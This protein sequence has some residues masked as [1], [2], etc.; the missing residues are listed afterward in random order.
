MSGKGRA[1]GSDAAGK[2]TK[3]Q[4][5]ERVRKEAEDLK[6]AEAQ[7]KGKA[8]GRPSGPLCKALGEAGYNDL[9]VPPDVGPDGVKAQPDTPASG[10]EKPAGTQAGGSEKPGGTVDDPGGAAVAQ[11]AADITP[12]FIHECLFK[13]E[14]GDGLLYA[15]LHRDKFLFNKNACEWYGWT[16]VHWEPDIM[17]GALAAVENVVECNLAEAE[18]LAEAIRAAIKKDDPDEL[19]RLKDKR[20]NFY[21]RARQLRGVNRRASCLE[22]SHT[23]DAPLAI[24]GT[25]FDLDPMLLAC[26]NGVIALRSGA[27]QD[28]RRK[29]YISMASAWPW[30][31][32]DEPCPLWEKTL[33]EI[34]NKNEDLVSYIRRLMGYALTGL[35]TERVFVCFQGQ[36]WNGK[37]VIVNTITNILSPLAGPIQSEMLLDQGRARSAS[38]PSPDIMMLKG[39][40]MAFASETD[41]GRRFSS[42][43]VKWLTGSDILVGRHLNEKR[44]IRFKPT[45]AL[46]LLTNAKP[47]APANDFAFWERMHL[48]PFTLSFVKRAPQAPN[49]R[50]ADLQLEEKLRSEYSGILAWLVR[51]ALEW[52]KRG[53]DPPEAVTDATAEYRRDEDMAADFVEEC[54]I[55]EPG[56]KCQGSDLYTR[57]CGWYEDNIG[58][59]VPS[60]TWFGKQMASKF[61]KSRVSGCIWY[62]GVGVVARDQDE[63]M[64]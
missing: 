43:R 45:H 21:K 46:F 22:M 10:S 24:E 3:D 8:R 63:P 39:L 16:G 54:L 17:G 26:K 48:V 19:K 27:M 52:Q 42:S 55:I 37:G 29:D 5:A 18:N 41:E 60:N 38:G 49:E 28:G 62:H 6:K 14:L 9:G 40:R 31:G 59:K 15:A 32:I 30:K 12:E 13:N 34:F 44:F 33:L 56:A 23:N 36:G 51:G 57:F 25:E 50:P 2:S 11:S 53:L 61:D 20:D 47:H 35:T 58:K 7:K 64:L 1:A 4:V